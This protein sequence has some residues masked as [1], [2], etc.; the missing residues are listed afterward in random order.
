ESAERALED[1]RREYKDYTQ[2]DRDRLV[3]SIDLRLKSSR[4]QA[5]NVREELR[6][7]EKMYEA[8]DL[9]EETEEIVLKRQRVAAEMAD[10]MLESAKISHERTLE[11]ALPRNDLEQREALERV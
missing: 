11:R 4:Q 2:G 8:D 5:E 3:K 10:F 1:A 6:Q 9:T 7:L